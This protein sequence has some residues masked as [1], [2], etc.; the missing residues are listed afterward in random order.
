[1]N[2]LARKMRRLTLAWAPAAALALA[3][4]SG[5]SVESLLAAG[6]A[7]AAKREHQAAV[8]QFKSALQK[9]P[10]SVEARYLL[11]KALLDAANPAAAVVELSKALDQ[12]ADA[13][14]VVPELARA[15]LLVGDYKKITSLYG[16]MTLADAKAQA[17]LK[18]TVATAW[19]GLGDRSKTLAAVDAALKAVPDFPPALVLQARIEA[20]RGQFDKATQLVA[21]ALQRDDKLHDAW[22]LKGEILALVNKDEKA[23][24]DAFQKALAIEPAYIPSHLAL[25]AQRLRARDLNGAQAQADQLR[26]VLPKHPQTVLLDTRMAFAKEDFKKARELTQALLRLA[27][28]SSEILYLAGAIEQQLGAVVLAESHFAKALQINPD[29]QAARRHL[30][31]VYLQVG[32]PARALDILQPLMAAGTPDATLYALAGMAY[33]SVGNP[34]SAEQAFRQALSIKPDLNRVKTALALSHLNR[35]DAQTAFNELQTIAAESGQDTFASQAIISARL[36]RREYGEALAEVNKLVAKDGGKATTLELRG[37]IQLLRQDLVAARADFNAALK[38]DPTLF[39]VTVNLASLDIL[40]KNPAGAR[41]RLESSLQQE[42]RNYHARLALGGLRLGQGAPT[43][44]L[45]TLFS[46]GIKLSPAEV[47]LRLALVD[48]LVSKRQFKDALAAAQEAVLALPGD[49]KLLDALGRA[50]AEAGDIEQAISTFRRVADADQRSAA[51]HLRLANIYSAS[52]RK[53]AAEIALRKALELEP[54]SDPAQQAL[55]SLMLSSGR[56]KEAIELARKMQ[57]Q[58]PS[59]V[60]GYAFEANVHLQQKNPD[61][62]LATYKRGLAVKDHAPELALQFYLTLQRNGRSAEGDRFG[63]DWIKSH[64]EDWAFDYQLAVTALRRGN[65]EQA[66]TRL[67]RIVELK[68]KAALALNNLAWAIASRGQPG[69]SEFA[70]R[71]LKLVPDN[72]AF[73]DTLA[74]ALWAEKAPAQ[75]LEAQRR[76]VEM[77][78]TEPAFRLSLARMALEAGDKTLARA[79]IERLKALGN[80]YPQQAEVSALAKK[81]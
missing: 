36:S 29:L 56:L 23:A 79:E 12:Q 28:N 69:G 30:A 26:K 19:A 55:A 16:E 59:A 54:N 42:P 10:Q 38:A 46:E 67:R 5:D 63:A 53:P 47:S 72:P 22:H 2:P 32:Q 3:S 24:T 33:L 48:Y 21:L 74:F 81:L 6:K 25:A 52:N 14:K 7:H 70:Q 62:A 31:Q 80:S 34:V 60:S 51:P 73:M 8:I 39:A 65:F 11:G 76:A 77:A 78:P 44:E 41:A 75:A 27:P 58:R 9:D 50:Q 66:E 61:Q 17:S 68:P 35:G 1:M 37:R 49:P 18:S 45:R 64:P 43:E 40:E 57:A 15:Y 71:A 20:G 4:C 13:T